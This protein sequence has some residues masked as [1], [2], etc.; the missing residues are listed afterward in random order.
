MTIL[1]KQKLHGWTECF[2]YNPP[3][4]ITEV[5]KDRDNKCFTAQVKYTMQTNVIPEIQTHTN[6][7]IERERERERERE[8]GL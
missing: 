8:S 6:D 3:Y 7:G 1:A 5:Q 2:Q 4:F